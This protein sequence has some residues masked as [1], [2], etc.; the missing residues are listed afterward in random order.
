MLD[1]LALKDML[2]NTHL[3]RKPINGDKHC[4]GLA[5]GLLLRVPK[6]PLCSRVPGLNYS[7]AIFHDDGIVRTF[8]HGSQP[9]QGGLREFALGNVFDGEKDYCGAAARDLINPPP[10]DQHRFPADLR[11]VMRHRKFFHHSLL[12]QYLFQQFSEPGNIPLLIPQMVE[13][14]AYG[15][16][17]RD[18]ELRAKW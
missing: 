16:G 1:V 17:L 6:E 8:N 10:A 2:Q 3:F 14:L 7:V 18:S 12:R 9:R 4:N 11:K 15:L 5:D 13:K